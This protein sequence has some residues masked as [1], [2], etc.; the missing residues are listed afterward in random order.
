MP[1][2]HTIKFIRSHLFFNNKNV[3][4]FDCQQKLVQDTLDTILEADIPMP[5][6]KSQD[7]KSEIPK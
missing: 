5:F 3:L 2:V 7:I 1:Q 4:H 6:P